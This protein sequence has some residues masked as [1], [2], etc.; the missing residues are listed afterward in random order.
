MVFPETRQTRS[1]VPER[2]RSLN[3]SISTAIVTVENTTVVERVVKKVVLA[4]EAEAAA[5]IATG[6]KNK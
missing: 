1:D 5:V 6:S 2:H 3:C 4:P